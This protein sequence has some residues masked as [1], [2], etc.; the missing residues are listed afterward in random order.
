M[1][2]VNVININSAEKIR[3]ETEKAEKIKEIERIKEAQAQ[4]EKTEKDVLRITEQ[5]NEKIQ[6]ASQYGSYYA[7]YTFYTW[8]ELY[9]IK[10]I[11]NALTKIFKKAGYGVRYHPYSDSWTY[12]SGKIGQFTVNWYK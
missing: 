4:Q 1:I 8:Q 7:A 12:R 10:E 3:I 6:D 9:N 5:L 2:E 11:V